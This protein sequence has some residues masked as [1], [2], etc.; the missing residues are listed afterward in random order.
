M[1]KLLKYFDLLSS[2]SS[3][4]S[5]VRFSVVNIKKCAVV[6]FCRLMCK[7]TVFRE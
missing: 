1:L 7:F 6:S 4:G 2:S 5:R 3:S